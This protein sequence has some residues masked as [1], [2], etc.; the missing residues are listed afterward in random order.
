[1]PV[2]PPGQRQI[3]DISDT[4]NFFREPFYVDMYA[5]GQATLPFDR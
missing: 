4:L 2:K 5:E 3:D 1:M